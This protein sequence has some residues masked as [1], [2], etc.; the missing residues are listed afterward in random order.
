MS[1][2]KVN[3][4]HERIVQAGL[5]CLRAGGLEGLT[6]RAVAAELGTSVG[7]IYRACG[8]MDAL[9][10]RVLERAVEVLKAYTRRAYTPMPF[11]NV[12]VGVVVFAREEPRLYR[13]LFVERHHCPV[14]IE[15]FCREI[16]GVLAADPVLGTLPE[17]R[18]EALLQDLWVY[19]HGL[20]MSIVAGL[21]D[22]SSDEAV[23][24]RIGRVGFLL[25]T[26][27]FDGDPRWAFPPGVDPAA[28]P[29]I[30]PYGKGDP[31]T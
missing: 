24:E 27:A 7:P 16:A 18:R 31:L 8:S 30:S 26:A 17:T 14:V 5:R 10:Q 20:A 9:E 6:A 15:T 13:T 1:P 19:S 21:T 11:R 29:P 25:I 2:R 23:N 4:P 22:D 3:V 28:C 12:G